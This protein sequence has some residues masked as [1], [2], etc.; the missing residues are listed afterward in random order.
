VL[1]LI[2]A[3]GAGL[4][5]DPDAE[6]LAALERA[7]RLGADFVELDV[8]RCRDGA[9]VLAHDRDLAVPGG[10]RRIAELALAEV[11]A[12][13]HT[14]LSYDTALAGLA[15]RTGAHLD[16]KFRSAGSAHELAA[17]EQAVEVLGAG[18]VL[19]TTGNVRAIHAVRA[20]ARERHPGLRAALS[21]GGSV[22]G[23]R[24]AD[25]LRAHRDQLFP[26]RRLDEADANAVA[27]NHW[28]A[29]L[30]VG[31]VAHRRGLPLAVWTVDRP[32][33]LRHWLRPGRA[34]TVVTNRPDVALRLRSEAA[35]TWQDAGMP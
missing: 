23:R 34:W 8:R 22:A 26:A 10:R 30:T 21:V 12:A 9:L 18:S 15:G 28:L 2:S 16:L 17:V 24:P 6:P 19:V 33:L 14:L 7:A 5:L 20:W 4:G 35:A 1:P 27:A 29:L 13:G 31:R 32:R 25:W 11:E 3:H